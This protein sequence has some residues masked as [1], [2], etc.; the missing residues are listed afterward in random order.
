MNQVAYAG[1]IERERECVCVYD[2]GLGNAEAEYQSAVRIQS[3][4]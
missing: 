2:R 4:M 1:I 3:C